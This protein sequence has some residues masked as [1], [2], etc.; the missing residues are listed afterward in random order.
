[1]LKMSV[2]NVRMDVNNVIKMVVLFVILD[3]S[4]NMQI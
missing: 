1:M 3:I 4:Y 2:L